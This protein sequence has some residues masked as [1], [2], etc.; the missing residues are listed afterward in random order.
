VRGVS[1]DGDRCRLEWGRDG[2]RRAA[3]RGDITVIVDT[4]SFSSAV[5]TAVRHGGVIYP[6]SLEDDLDAH[7]ARHHAEVAVPRRDVPMK[8][9]F[10][11]SPSTYV[12]IEAG[13][14]VVV[15]SPNGALCSLHGRRAPHL[16]VG[17]LN[18][19]RATATAVAALLD[20][21]ALSVTVVACGER[22]HAP[23]DD[24]PLRFAVEDYLGAGAIL[25]HL[26]HARSPEA[27]VCEAAFTG[28]RH[29]LERLLWESASGRELRAMGFGGDVTHAARL[30]AYDAVAVL[31][32]ERLHRLDP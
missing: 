13:T 31:D 32:G 11:L 16:F 26:P 14:R 18:N 27:L 19:A 15:A 8:G 24:G 7:R 6:C 22:W 2:A 10:S 21:S 17:A 4:L 23:G 28:C 25:T 3:E 30:D 29:E 20:A 9:R 5:A 12:G 1:Q